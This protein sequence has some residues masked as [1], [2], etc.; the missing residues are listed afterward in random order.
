MTH[1]STIHGP[2]VSI[3]EEYL[4]GW[5]RARADLDNFRKRTHAG[6]A[7][8]AQQQLRRVIDPILSLN[9]NFRAMI[10]HVPDDLQ[11]HTWVTGVLH[12]ARQ[13]SDILSQFGII[14]IG[15]VGDLFDPRVHEAVEHLE[16]S[17]E[18]TGHVTAVIQAG[19]QLQDK[20]IRPAKVKV[21]A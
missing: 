14:E 18:K 5:Q 9:D 17:S 11:D 12:I 2:S 16:N 3:A 21:A 19:Y 4:S 15:H 20:I 1:S 13:L 8:V 6:Q 10:Q 7:E